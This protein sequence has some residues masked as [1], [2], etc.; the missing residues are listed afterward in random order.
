MSLWASASTKSSSSSKPLYTEAEIA[1]WSWKWKM[2]EAF[3][4]L[5]QRDTCGV[6]ERIDAIR[7]HDK[8]QQNSLSMADM[9]LYVQFWCCLADH[10]RMHDVTTAG[11]E[12]WFRC[13]DTITDCY[14]F[15]LQYHLYQLY[16]EMLRYVQSVEA[17]CS[18]G[19]AMK[20]MQMTIFIRLYAHLVGCYNFFI[21][22]SMDF[23][24]TPVVEAY[25]QLQLLHVR[26]RQQVL[27]VYAKHLLETS[28]TRMLNTSDDA[29]LEEEEDDDDDDDMRMDISDKSLKEVAR[30]VCICRSYLESMLPNNTDTP[31]TDSS[32][33][34]Q[35]DDSDRSKVNEI[36]RLMLWLWGKQQLANGNVEI[37]HAAFSL[38]PELQSQAKLIDPAATTPASSSSSSTPTEVYLP[39]F[40][41]PMLLRG[42]HPMFVQQLGPIFY[43]EDYIAEQTPILRKTVNIEVAAAVAD[44]SQRL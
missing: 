1:S 10:M 2:S 27:Y 11:C 19:S 43:D 24:H 41:Q 9:L 20:R 23:T 35:L 5:Q 40:T 22:N 17:G 36:R 12:L 4:F 31:C 8:Q 38:H 6:F 7:F 33:D 14:W 16:T 28:F 44:S 39:R 15:D 3:P 34:T 25:K 21:E 18:R 32:A 26:L 30:T 13:G 29:H 42:I 37:A